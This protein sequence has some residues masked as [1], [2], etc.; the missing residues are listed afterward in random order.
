M[1]PVPKPHFLLFS[2][3]NVADDKPC[4]ESVGKWRFLLE[5]ADGSSKLEATDEEPMSLNRLQLL[6]VVRGLEALDQ[7]SRVTLITASKY[8]ARGIRFG[9]NQ[10]RDNLWQW[11]RFGQMQ[12]VKNCDLWQRVDQAMCYHRVE[13]RSLGWGANDE[14][15][16]Y[17]ESA[18]ARESW[19]KG[20]IVAWLLGRI[21]RL[22]RRT[23]ALKSPLSC[24]K[25]A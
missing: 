13:C 15:S 22:L 3:S 1:R 4:Q 19:H 21:N 23:A 16:A 17:S 11:E 25:V 5:A 18:M 24:A 12:P 14:P 6:G 2:D 8:V 20:G 9:I 7:P 10:W